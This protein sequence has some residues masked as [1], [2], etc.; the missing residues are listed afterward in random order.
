MITNLHNIGIYSFRKI[1]LLKSAEKKKVYKAILLRGDEIVFDSTGHGLPLFIPA[2]VLKESKYP[3]QIQIFLDHNDDIRNLVGYAD[4]IRYKE[5]E[6]L[7]CDLYFYNTSLANDVQRLLDA[8][9]ISELSVKM[10]TEEHFD[11]RKQMN[12]VDKIK[13]LINAS[14]VL[15]GASKFAKIKV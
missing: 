15:E 6:G 14:L 11:Y 9:A 10:L 12:V 8:H 1:D 13:K 2:R 5:K 7:I 3:V 4:N